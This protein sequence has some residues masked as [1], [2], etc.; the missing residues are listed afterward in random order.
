MQVS[1]EEQLPDDEDK[2]V[3]LATYNDEIVALLRKLDTALEID[4]GQ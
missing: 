1:T 3:R 4:A 2:V